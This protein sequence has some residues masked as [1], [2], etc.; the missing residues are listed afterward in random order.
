MG[1]MIC[2]F[3]VIDVLVLFDS[4]IIGMVFWELVISDL[5]YFFFYEF[6]G[7]IVNIFG[8]KVVYGIFCLRNL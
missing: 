1:C 5:C 8:C 7:C 6:F 3:N 4:Y 2:F